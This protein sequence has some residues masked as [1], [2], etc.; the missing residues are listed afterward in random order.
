MSK[1]KKNL[2]PNIPQETLARARAEL[3]QGYTAPE[4]HVTTRQ[5]TSKTP[6]TAASGPVDLR[7]EYHYVISDLQSMGLLAGLLFVAL[8]AVSLVVI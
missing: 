6:S 5:A 8:I 1:A 3:S 7:S 4:V 2:R